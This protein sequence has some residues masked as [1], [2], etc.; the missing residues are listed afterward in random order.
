MT[1]EQGIKPEAAR[2]L[3][4]AEIEPIAL[5]NLGAHAAWLANTVAPKNA[6]EGAALQLALKTVT[7]LPDEIGRDGHDIR[8]RKTCTLSD[9]GMLEEG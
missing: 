6:Q 2:L 9:G 8:F 3:L 4:R 5:N 1:T 7:A